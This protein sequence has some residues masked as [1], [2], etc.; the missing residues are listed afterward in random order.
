MME[1]A[2]PAEFRSNE[3]PPASREQW[4]ELVDAVLGK[5]GASF[6]SLVTRT[7][8]GIELQPLYTLEDAPPVPYALAPVKQGWDVRQRHAVPDPVAVLNDLEGG[9]TSLWLALPA[10]SLE[11][12]LDGVHL[13]LAP[14]VL[15]GDVE[16]ARAM[17]RIYDQAPVLADQVRGNL[18]LVPSG[19][20]IDVIRQARSSFPHL[21]TVVVDALPFH[22]A[23]GSDSE[24]LGASLA[25]AV[26]HLRSLTEAGLG[27]A[28]AFGQLEFRY[29]AT[30]DQFTTIA[31]LRAA[32]RLWARVAEVSGVDVPQVQHAV[33]SS[34]MMTRRD[35][36][37]NMLRTTVATL[38]AGLG[39]ADSVTVQPFDAAIGLPDEFARR[40][41]RNT[42]NLL[43]EESHLGA[44]IDPAAGSWY[45]ERLTDEL[46][47]A[48]WSWFQEIERAG[49]VF[50]AREL[51][52]VRIAETWAKRSARLA[53]RSDPITGVS[54]FPNLG[55]KPVVREPAS[56][57]PV[58]R[59]P[60]GID[61][62]SQTPRGDAPPTPIISS[63]SDSFGLPRVR[64][65]Q[66][67]E[68]LRDLA[69]AQPERPQ[70]FLATLGPVAAHTARATF[71]ANLFNAG[72]FATPAAGPTRT[73]QDVASRFRESGAEIAVLC[74]S[75]SGYAEQADQVVE[76]LRAV[77]AR[78][79]LLAGR[80]PDA[81][82][83]GF[84]HT[85]CPALEILTGTFEFL[86]ITE[87][88]GAQR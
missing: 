60:V 2:L 76:A 86:G 31:K 54:E 61:T 81:E 19:E 73:P 37:V 75:D 1:L 3:F 46:A 44:V 72:G 68:E 56:R 62:D 50:Q 52:A 43:L 30:A 48:A 47:V 22:D 13:D 10:T 55:E 32:R 7:Y 88:Q 38:A 8:D 58:G 82:V 11:R 65:A 41:A 57:E 20:A 87:P 42:Q 64:Y 35:P 69:D 66:A 33:T 84:V 63:G 16:A 21:R 15:D 79:V 83:D 70:V 51:V 23:G 59:E 40:I 28:E 34:A 67:F 39:G 14:I 53:D 80:K 85:G 18:A 5:T 29:A 9:V 49:G 77:G 74:G 26:A 6:D 4:R 24:E 71:A 25:L 12:V 78:R 36:W 27:V 45:V 17:L